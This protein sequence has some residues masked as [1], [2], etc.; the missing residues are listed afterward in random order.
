MMQTQV[1]YSLQERW[2]ALFYAFSQ[3]QGDTNIRLYDTDK[4][5]PTALQTFTDTEPQR[6]MCMMPKRVLDVGGCEVARLLKLTRSG[7]VIPIRFEVPR[8]V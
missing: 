8:R 7:Y 5:R 4:E 3:N 6:G 2:S 1:L